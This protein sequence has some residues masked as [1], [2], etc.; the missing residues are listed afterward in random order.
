MRSGKFIF[1]LIAVIM[2]ISLLSACSKN[3]REQ[4]AVTNQEQKATETPKSTASAEPM[5]P[6]TVK[7]FGPFV[8][9]EDAPE[10]QSWN[11][12][13]A[14]KEVPGRTGVTVEWEHVSVDFPAQLGLVIASGDLPDLIVEV[15]PK[16]AG[17]YGVQGAIIPLQ[18]L[19]AEHAP[20]LSKILNDYPEVKGQITAPDGNIYFFPRVLL[21]PRTQYWAGWHIRKSWVEDVGKQVPTNLDEVYDVLKAIKDKHPDKYPLLFDPRSLIWEFGV[22]S[23]GVNS[24]NDFFVEDD[25]LKYGPTDPRYKEALVYLNRLYKEKILDPEYLTIADGSSEAG[26]ARITQEVGGFVFGSWAGSLTRFNQLLEADG[27]QPDFVA[28]RPPG[29]GNLLARLN[30][31]ADDDGLVITSSSKYAVEITKMM[32]YLYSEEGKLL[33]YFGIEGDTFEMKE[34]KPVA[35][36]KVLNSPLGMLNYRNT[37]IGNSSEWPSELMTEVYVS[38]LSHPEAIKGNLES[39][40]YSDDIKPPTLQ[41]TNEERERVQEIE[42][43]LNTFIDENLHAFINGDKSLDEYDSFVTTAEEIGVTELV[44]IYNAAFA[45]YTKAIK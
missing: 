13:L 24:P 20:H 22:G 17:Q 16:L 23:R 43:D 14:W 12:Q 44:D 19:I 34:G 2:V 39:I 8:P 38:T 30:I 10:I 41:F 4:P 29:A 3:N 42:R 25:T 28:M 6:I 7:G 27:K 15:D 5:E 9:R 45:R 1:F 35:T 37:Y 18:D 33:F 21:D 40:E 36:E 31:V 32:D 11:D 26:I